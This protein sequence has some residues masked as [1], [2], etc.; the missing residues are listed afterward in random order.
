MKRIVKLNFSGINSARLAAKL[1]AALLCAA[2]SVSLGG[3]H[4]V[5]EEPVSGTKN[6]AVMSPEIM[7]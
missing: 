5:S 1:A 2:V 7:G 3:C 4:K 6:S